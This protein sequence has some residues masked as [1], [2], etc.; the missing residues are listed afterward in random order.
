ML[1]G[2]LIRLRPV[3]EADVD[4]LY[5]AHADVRN[6]GAFFPLGVVSETTFKGRFAE[7]GYW[8]SEEGC[9]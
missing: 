7:H 3:R 1:E 4:E 6:R 2:R 9:S 8:Q 5:T